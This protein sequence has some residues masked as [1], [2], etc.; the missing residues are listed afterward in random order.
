[1]RFFGEDMRN[2]LN[3][4]IPNS[5]EL[6]FTSSGIPKETP[7][8]TNLSCFLVYR[9]KMLLAHNEFRFFTMG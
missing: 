2:I 4:N 6:I 1:M 5:L 9:Y 8:F 3:Q 7:R